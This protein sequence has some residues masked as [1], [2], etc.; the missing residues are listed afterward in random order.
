[1][2]ILGFPKLSDKEKS[3]F[4]VLEA[5]KAPRL[6]FLLSKESPYK[7]RLSQLPKDESQALALFLELLLVYLIEPLICR[8]DTQRS[9]SVEG[10]SDL[11][12]EKKREGLF[13]Y[14]EEG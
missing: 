10:E 3:L 13:I 2:S 6:E 11:K 7:A 9:G 5:F 14:F 1:M 4:E 12:E 8:Y